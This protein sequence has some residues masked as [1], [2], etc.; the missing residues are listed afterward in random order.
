MTP[1]VKDILEVLKAIQVV[2]PETSEVSEYLLAHSDLSC[3]ISPICSK[4]IKTFS[5]DAKLFLE[6]YR[7]PEIHDE[8]LTIYIR[9]NE[10]EKMILDRIDEAMSEFEPALGSASGWLLVTTDFLLPK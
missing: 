1:G 2:I 9:K 8:Y 10:Y 4:L 6:V 7:D 3:L 5:D